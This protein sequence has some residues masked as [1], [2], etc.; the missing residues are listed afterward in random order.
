MAPKNWA[1]QAEAK[2]YSALE[3]RYQMI[4]YQH[5]PHGYAH[6]EDAHMVRGTHEC[7]AQSSW[8][9]S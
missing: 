6:H 4:E 9:P 2:E 8:Y 5:C 7:E 1:L 3:V